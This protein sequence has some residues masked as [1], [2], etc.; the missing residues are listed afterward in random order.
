M[1]G[2][3]SLFCSSKFP[4]AS[5]IISSKFIFGHVSSKRFPSPGVGTSYGMVDQNIEVRFLARIDFCSPPTSILALG[6]HPVFC[7]RG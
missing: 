4:R 1:G 5:E 6:S 7:F 2:A 3:S